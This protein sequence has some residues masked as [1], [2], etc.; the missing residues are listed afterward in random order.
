MCRSLLESCLSSRLT[1]ASPC[2]A[3]WPPGPAPPSHFQLHVLQGFI[4]RLLNCPPL[5]NMALPT[6]LSYSLP[7]RSPVSSSLSGFSHDR[8]LLHCRITFGRPC[9]APQGPT[10]TLKRLHRLVL[11][12]WTSPRARAHPRPPCHGGF[13]EARRR[14]PRIGWR[15]SRQVQVLLLHLRPDSSCLARLVLEMVS[16]RPPVRLGLPAPKKALLSRVLCL[17]SRCEN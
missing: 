10:S 6:L 2:C 13:S 15:D 11:P 8:V 17:H 3:M 9:D 1:K 4:L 5:Q 7:F 12:P 14:G 16:A